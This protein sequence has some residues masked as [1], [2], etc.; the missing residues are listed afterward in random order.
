MD[1]ERIPYDQSYK[2]LFSEPEMVSSVLQDFVPEDFVKNIDF[3]TLD[4]VPGSYVTDDCRERHDDIIW[5]VKCNEEWVYLFILVEFQSTVDPWMAVRIQGYTALLWQDLINTGKIK[6]GQKLPPV[7][8]LVLY[9]GGKKWTAA[10]DVADL[11]Y[12]ITGP[13][14]AYQPHQKYFLLEESQVSEKSIK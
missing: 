1:N 8:P 11:Q 2:L 9:N 3:S 13:L 12:P 7:F 6:A 14:A 5:R 10:Q 4:R